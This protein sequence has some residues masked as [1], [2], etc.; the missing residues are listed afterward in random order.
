MTKEDRARVQ[1]II[2]QAGHGFWILVC[3]G[4]TF[5]STSQIEVCWSAYTLE[6]ALMKHLMD[7]NTVGFYLKMLKSTTGLDFGKF[8]LVKLC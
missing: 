8:S 7:S 5:L 6:K 3:P 4:T 2:C 1:Q